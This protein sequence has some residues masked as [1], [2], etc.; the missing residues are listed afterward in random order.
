MSVVLCYISHDCSSDVNH[1]EYVVKPVMTTHTNK[2]DLLD[3]ESQKHDQ[4]K[5]NMEG[6]LEV[7]FLLAR[8]KN[9]TYGKHDVG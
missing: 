4:N 8:R 5:Y 3:M 2:T 1:N 6:I 7:H 9:T